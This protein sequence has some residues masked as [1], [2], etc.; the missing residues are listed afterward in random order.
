MGLQAVFNYKH[1]RYHTAHDALQESTQSCESN[2]KNINST[3]NDFFPKTSP[4]NIR[5]PRHN[6]ENVRLSLVSFV[7]YLDDPLFAQT[8]A[9]WDS[10]RVS[11]IRSSQNILL[12]VE[13]A[14]L[15]DERC[16]H[17]FSPWNLKRFIGFFWNEWYP[18]CPIIHKPTFDLLCAP[19]IL[20]VP[21]VRNPNS[22]ST[23]SSSR[24]LASFQLSKL[25]LRVDKSCDIITTPNFALLSNTDSD[26]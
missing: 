16:L 9:I 10:F 15:S 26:I 12:S 25:S 19:S 23:I 17:F 18:H 8:K 22:W 20:L 7:E 3:S 1:Q 5:P 21:M 4:T 24:C 6:Q 11:R 2:S 13:E 14:D